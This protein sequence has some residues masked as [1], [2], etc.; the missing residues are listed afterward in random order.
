MVSIILIQVLIFTGSYCMPRT[1]EAKTER[2]F[3]K[4]SL[5]W[6]DRK[7]NRKRDIHKI[8][9]LEPHTSCNALYFLMFTLRSNF[10]GSLPR[11]KGNLVSTLINFSYLQLSFARKILGHT[12]FQYKNIFH[13]LFPPPLRWIFFSPYSGSG[14]GPGGEGRWC[15]HCIAH[16][17]WG[18]MQSRGGHIFHSWGPLITFALT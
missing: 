10:S 11:L 16:S 14:E 13:V 18:V 12:K 2:L 15:F 8:R 4:S 17:I 9:T 7:T 6:K 1:G 3:Q 5:F